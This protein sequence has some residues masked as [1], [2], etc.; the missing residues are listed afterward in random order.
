MTFIYKTL[1]EVKLLHEYFLTA[2]DGT[3]IFEKGNQEDRLTIL[4]GEHSLDRESINSV[5]EFKFPDYLKSRYEGYHLKLIPSY[6]GVKVAARVLQKKLDD[7]SIVYDP[8]AKM[9]ADANIFIEMSKKTGLFDRF[10]NGRVKT[11]LPAIYFFSNQ[12][13]PGTF[14]FL[15]RS[16]SGF[17]LNYSYEQGELA[18]FGANDIREYY[19]DSSGD[20][21]ATIKGNLFASENDRLLLPSKFQYSFNEPDISQALFTLKNNNGEIVKSINST[22]ND[23][24]RKVTLDFSDMV[25]QSLVND[26]VS[27]PGDGYRLEILGNNGF[28]AS[29]S[30]IFNNP[31]YNQSNWGVIN[32]KIDPPLTSFDL[33][34]S[35][36][37]L[38]KRKTGGGI[39]QSHPIFEIHL[40]SRSA[41][42][43]YFNDKG[44]ELKLI[45]DLQDYLFKEGKTLISKRPAPVSRSN[46][47]MSKEGSTERKFVPN[48]VSYDLNRDEKGRLC[49]DVMV[50]ES[51]LFKVV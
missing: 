30:I 40:K 28:S 44:K 32:M 42:W 24:F 36:G 34:A 47:F 37:Y 48:P 2:A 26:Q 21:W 10:T 22:T 7:G 43:R 14:P 45:T 18:S 41:Y 3:T 25:D 51:E 4:A 33:L 8:L 27:I 31:L 12:N 46:F 16:I 29:H 19:K 23:V 35:D 1:F 13:T 11:A 5:L 49:F 15:T 6:S 50:P 17:N 20:H 39:D 9:S 38:I